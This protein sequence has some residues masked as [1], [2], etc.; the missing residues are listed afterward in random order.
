VKIA[1]PVFRNTQY[2][3]SA[4]VIEAALARGWEVEC[5]HDYSHPRTGTKGDLF[6]GVDLA[7]RFRS[8][9]PT[10]SVFQG[11]ADLRT[12]LADMN[13]VAAVGTHALP[14]ATGRLDPVPGVRWVCQQYRLDSMVVQSPESLLGCDLLAWYSSWWHE[15]GG[16]YYAS[17]GLIADRDVYLRQAAARTVFVGLPELDAVPLIDGDEVRR[18]WGVPPKQPV[19]VLFPFPQGVGR[20]T[21]WPKRICAEP[22][23]LRQ[24]GHIALS[25]RFEYLRDVIN[26]W[27]DPNIVNAIRR[28]CDRN[29]AYLLVKS[30]TKTPIP[31]YTRAV[32]DRC[33]YDE[34]FYPATVLEALSIA[35]LSIGYYSTSVFESIALGVPSLCVTYTAGDY[36]EENAG[37]FLRFYTPEEGGPFQFRGVSTAASIP[38]ALDLLSSRTLSDFAMDPRAR[39]RYVERFLCHT[40]GNSGARTIDAVEQLLAQ[41]GHH[42]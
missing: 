41:H 32:A 17:E 23:R 22:S 42:S 33:V 18:R 34:G 27:N 4:P 35:S 7:P 37:H 2:R 10:F 31:A 1:V 20:A 8:G 40:S 19:V 15:W 16:A 13:A 14:A 12:R 30:R 3:V 11:Q 36:L 28:F 5:C 24:L 29:G 6:P 38:E 25:R 26:G 21:F 9:Q 39:Q